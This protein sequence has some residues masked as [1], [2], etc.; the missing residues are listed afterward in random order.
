MTPDIMTYLKKRGR[1]F[2]VVAIGHHYQQYSGAMI[3]RTGRFITI[4]KADGRCM[5]DI[6]TFQKVNPQYQVLKD[7][8]LTFESNSSH[9]ICNKYQTK[10][11]S[12][13][14]KRGKILL[15]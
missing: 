6:S 4:F 11:S 10:S 12:N 14:V 13:S 1:R 5:V 2:G 8:Q 15:T 7:F 9:L 3:F